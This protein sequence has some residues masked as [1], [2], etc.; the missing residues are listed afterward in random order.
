MTLLLTHFALLLFSLDYLCVQSMLIHFYYL[1]FNELGYNGPRVAFQA[2]Y[3]SQL[4]GFLLSQDK[5]ELSPASLA[6][7]RNPARGSPLCVY[8]HSWGREKLTAAAPHLFCRQKIIL[9]PGV[10]LTSRS[11]ILGA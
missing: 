8:A 9:H 1:S 2:S 10:L 11:K 3:Y 6:Y 4:E 7:P 5:I